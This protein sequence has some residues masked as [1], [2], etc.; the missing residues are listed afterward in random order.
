MVSWIP[1]KNAFDWSVWHF[2]CTFRVNENERKSLY[3]NFFLLVRLA[4]FRPH[5]IH[6]GRV[7]GV[8]NAWKTQA[9]IHIVLQ[10]GRQTG[11]LLCVFFVLFEQKSDVL[12]RVGFSPVYHL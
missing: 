11:Y 2:L 1:S 12:K 7:R 10:L 3:L 5:M 6:L 9:F 8:C 4:M